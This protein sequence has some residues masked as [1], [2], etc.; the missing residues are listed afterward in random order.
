M[1]YLSQLKSKNLSKE[2]CLLRV[3]FNIQ[4]PKD[5]F[6]LEAALPTIKF[7]I[8]KRAKIVLLSH[9]GRPKG[10]DRTLSLKPIAKI[11]SRLLKKPIKFIDFN[12]GTPDL[13]KLTSILKRSDVLKLKNQIS[14]ASVGSIFLLE[15]LR[16]LPAE[17]KN[18]TKLAKQ[19]ASLGTIYINDAFAVSHRKN[20]SVVAIAK[21]L[22]SYAGLLLEK[23]LK[24]LD[25]AI[26]KPRQPLV[27]IMGGAKISDKINLIKKFLTKAKYILI[28]GGLANTM[29]KA[30]GIDIGDS[31]FEPRMITSAKRLLKYKKIILPNDL[32]VHRNK[33]LDIGHL[34]I[35]RF[36]EIINKAK[37]IIWN[38]PMGYFEDKRFT[39]GSIAIVNAIIKNKAF[40]V[41]G[42]GETTALFTSAISNYQF[43]ISKKRLFVSTGGGAMLEYLAGKK[44]PGIKVLKNQILKIT[45]NIHN[46]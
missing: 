15:N 19:L 21:F 13:P 41:V 14:T 39:K 46:Y 4:S 36:S 1:R 11:F 8:K 22:P 10:Y 23:E 25:K 27:L 42:G 24:N 12:I 45:N 6:R 38:G 17:E 32:L 40:A 7:L 18:S 30:R 20:A 44:L 34:T 31:L 9:R 16:F 28:G 33:I 37:T 5:I 43:L 26:K 2:T 35:E 3:D 29:L